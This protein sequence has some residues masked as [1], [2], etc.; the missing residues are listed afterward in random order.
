M[1]AKVGLLCVV[2]LLVVGPWLAW[3]IG[4]VRAVV[5]LA[6][7]QILGGVALGP[8]LFGR[9]APETHAMVFG[10]PMLAALQGL[11]AIG[12]LLYVFVS[13][14]HL[15]A[16]RLRGSARGLVPVAVG[17]FAAPFVLGLGLGAWIAANVPGAIGPRGD[18]ASLAVA[19]AVCIAVTALPILAAI[20]RETGLIATRLGQMALALAA[21]LTRLALSRRAA[22]A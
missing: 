9:F 7:L 13:G 3:R 6:V 10:A 1:S 21:P 2:V 5:P 16:G 14:L 11:S 15:D 4:A 20:P 17:S 19:I 8:S 22:A 18:A 12:V